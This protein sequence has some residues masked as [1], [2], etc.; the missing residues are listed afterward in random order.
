MKKLA[1]CLSLTI[2]VVMLLGFSIGIV[3]ADPC[4]LPDFASTSFTDPLTIDNPYWPLVP[5]TTFVY[6]PV[7]N[8][9]NVV[10]TITVTN[11][12]KKISVNGKR[13]RCRVVY[14]VEEVDGYVTEETWDWY[15][16]DDEGNI[17]YCGEDTI[18]YIYDEEDWTLIDT[19]TEGSW[20]AGIDGALPGYLI[21]AE[22]SPGVCYQ[23]EYYEDEAEDVAK[24]LRLN[25][26]VTLENLGPYEDC[27]VTKEW[28]Q[29]DPGNVEN[30]YY[31]E[32]VGL[33]LIE[34]LKEKSARV[35]LVEI[36][37]P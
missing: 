36:I 28:T 31:F 8:E 1:L 10:N 35:E 9:D 22:P 18:E 23:Q 11:K 20:E 15:A 37:G 29:L 16:Q 19:S 3:L 21:L 24:V 13:I 7:P 4:E 25:A 26:E 34:E 27:L 5:G 33:V 17:W 32:G 14:D 2:A 12:T 6:E 30:K